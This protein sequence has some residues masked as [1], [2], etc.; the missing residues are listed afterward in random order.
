MRRGTEGK[1]LFLHEKADLKTVAGGALI[2][3]GMLVLLL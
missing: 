1:I 2:A 3:A